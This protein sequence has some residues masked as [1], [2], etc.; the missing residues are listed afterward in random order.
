MLI[1]DTVT[2]E[3]RVPV[4]Y[5]TSLMSSFEKEKQINKR[6]KCFLNCVEEFWSW[7]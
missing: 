2:L 4:S 7:S 1:D 6:G 3:I 5:S